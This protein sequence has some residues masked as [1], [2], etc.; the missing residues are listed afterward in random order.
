MNDGRRKER[1]DRGVKV[2]SESI[3]VLASPA[4]LAYATAPRI[5]LVFGLLLLPLVL[6]DAP[7]WNRVMLSACVMAFLA[8]SFDFLANQ[9]GLVCLGG[10]FFY[11][12]GA[13][14]A[15]LL[16]VKWHVPLVVSIPLGTVG[17]ALFCTLALLPCLALRG[18]YFAVV[19]LMYPLLAARLI[20][21]ADLLGGT[22]GFRGIEGFAST[23]WKQYALIGALLLAVFGLRRFVT[24][25]PGLVIRAVKDNDQA[26]RASGINVTWWRA[27]AL[28]I[29]ACLGCFAGAYYVHMYRNVGPSSFAP[30][31]SILPIAAT[32]IGGAGTIAGPVVGSLLLVP[33]GEALRDF[34]SLRIAVFALLLT[35]FVVLRSEGLLPFAA[36]KY[37]QFERWRDV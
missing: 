5:L 29:A 6:H 31:L 20:A 23:W 1:I 28:F 24:E 14:A 19:T 37:H 2:R 34:G 8:V 13:Y 3:Y 30:D 26:V 16:S 10:A 11:G 36:R 7:Y 22:D 4:E 12:V 9:A 17:G 18:I 15:A 27:K 32:V 21:A 35:A 33:L 25:A